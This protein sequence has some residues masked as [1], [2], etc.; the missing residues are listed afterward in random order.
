MLKYYIRFIS[1]FFIII[2]L[3]VD[4]GAQENLKSGNYYIGYIIKPG[5]DTIRG[6]IKYNSMIHNHYK[7]TFKESYDQEEE[8][9]VPLEIEA[10]QLADLHYLSVPFSGRDSF[11]KF[12]FML[13]IVEGPVSLY[14]WIYS[15][16]QQYFED[17]DF[18]DYTTS[19]DPDN[20]GNLVQFLIQREGEKPVDISSGKYTWKFNK[21][22]AKY[23]SDDQ[24][25]A[26]KVKKK[27]NG[28]RKENLEK[29]IREY[30]NS[31]IQNTEFRSEE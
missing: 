2:F 14:K 28:Y 31:R 19:I 9:F 27:E 15:E 5:Q 21:A 12:T 26:E 16:K 10:Y 30:N 23:L 18:W 8:I 17:N 29:I 3:L 22:M 7:V 6:K 1:I 20:P 25:L 4:S 11:K 24:E 13:V